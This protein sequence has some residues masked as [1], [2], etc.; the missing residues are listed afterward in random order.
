MKLSIITINKNNATGLEKTIQSVAAQTF[1]DYEYIVIDGVSDDGSVEVIK[2]YADKITYWVSEPDTGIYNAMNKGIRAARGDFC[3]FLNSADWLIEAVTLGNVFAEIAGLDEADIYYSDLVKDDYSMIVYPKKLNINNL[4]DGTISHQN[5]LIKRDLFIRY[6]YY[7]ES[8]SIASDWEYFLKG[9][10]IH[11][12]KFLHIN[13]NI[14]IFDQGGISLTD[15]KKRLVEDE[16]VIRN[17]FGELADSIIELKR[18][19]DTC[20]VD[21]ITNWGNSFLLEFMLKAYRFIARRI[22]KQTPPP[23]GRIVAERMFWQCSKNTRGSYSR[24]V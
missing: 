20:Y 15:Y 8:L 5:T 14:A 12:I 13:T 6:G 4:I 21:I 24:V 10:W 18:Y 9:Y 2:Q 19:R 3:L 16:T 1:S 11:K 7:N 17:V 22:M 23:V